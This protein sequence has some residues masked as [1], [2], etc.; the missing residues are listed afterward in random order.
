MVTVAERETFVISRT[1]STK[2]LTAGDYLQY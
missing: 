1:E 2:K